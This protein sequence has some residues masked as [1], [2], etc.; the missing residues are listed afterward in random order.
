[1]LSRFLSSALQLCLS[2]SL[3]HS[4]LACC[5]PN[6]RVPHRPALRTLLRPSLPPPAP[7][8]E[9]V[10]TVCARIRP[11]GVFLAPTSLFVN[12][13]GVSPAA[14]AA[15]LCIQHRQQPPESEPEPR[16][17]RNSLPS[18]KALPSVP[19][20]SAQHGSRRHPG[21]P[22]APRR[23]A[24]CAPAPL[25]WT[26]LPD[27]PAAPSSFW[28]PEPLVAVG[29]ALRFTAILTGKAAPRGQGYPHGV[30]LFF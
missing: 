22:V 23:P 10:N 21:A 3:A 9:T 16:P 13:R 4:F 2:G 17:G 14:F 25:C 28:Q 5:P 24:A 11:R 29:P 26:A 1:M 30:F 8:L 7:S 20:P 15:S 18:V 27:R 19:R 12:C 6:T